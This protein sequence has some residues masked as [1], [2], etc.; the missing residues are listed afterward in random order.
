MIGSRRRVRATFES[1]LEEGFSR[2]TIGQVRAPIGLDLGAETPAE[3]AVSIAAE[4]V[5]I[6]RG[7][8]GGP[9]REV[10]RVLDRLIPPSTDDPGEGR[11]GKEPI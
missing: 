11:T 8:P 4:I 6:W 2:E 5:Q 7:G 9:M 10:E 3:I 1:L